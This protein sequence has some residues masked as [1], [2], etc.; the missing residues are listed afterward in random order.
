MIKDCSARLPAAIGFT[1]AMT[2][3]IAAQPQS[4]SGQGAVSSSVMAWWMAHREDAGM[5]ALDLLILW[6]GTP[7]WLFRA[8]GIASYGS[9][10][11]G[12]GSDTISH[13]VLVG[14]RALTWTL[15]LTAKRITILDRTFSLADVNVIL[16]D[17]GDNTEGSQTVRALQIDPTYAAEPQHFEWAVRGSWELFQFLQCDAQL[18]DPRQ[19]V[20]ADLV[21][22]RFTGR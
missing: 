13:S 22:A 15:D 21:C 16:I 7:G 8:G 5:S 14:N 19:Q 11:Q 2:A 1:L 17:G 3:Q 12:S 20:I 4:E 9:G 18:D 6:R 10:R